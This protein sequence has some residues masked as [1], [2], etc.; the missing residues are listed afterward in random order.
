MIKKIIIIGASGIGKE[1]LMT[2]Y[3]C[4][5]N[6]KKFEILGFVDDDQKLWNKTINEIPVLGGIEWIFKN[7][8]KS[9][10][11]IIA[12]GDPLS[13]QK[14]VNKLKD[15]KIEFALLIHPSANISKFSTIGK[16]CVIQPGV[17]IMPDTRIGDFVYVNFDSSIAHDT[18]IENFVTISPGVHINGNT[19]IGML[20]DIGTGTVMKQ[21]IEIGKKCVIGAG[22]VLINNVPD[23]SLFVG[24]PGKLKKKI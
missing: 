17:H 9:F 11:C 2:L 6:L 16:G 5:K 19:K 3:D 15:K 4:N 22:T 7:I 8:E 20:T 21:N 12:I 13:R 24:V 18:I 1:V 10:A 23:N 14:I